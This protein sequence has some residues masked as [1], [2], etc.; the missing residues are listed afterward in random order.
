MK[1]WCKI[2]LLKL[3]CV[4]CRAFKQLN[5]KIFFYSNF[6][7]RFNPKHPHQFLL[8]LL[9]R[10]HHC[11]LL[12][13]NHHATEIKFFRFVISV[14]ETTL[15]QQLKRNDNGV[16]FGFLVFSVLE[17]NHGVNC[18]HGLSKLL[19]ASKYSKNLP[20]MVQR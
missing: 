3:Q 11:L 9:S 18:V 1:K 6:Y 8:S 17:R 12:S 5:D 10:N 19:E 4:S 13:P 20:P 15:L 14:T 7:F 2:T 16:S